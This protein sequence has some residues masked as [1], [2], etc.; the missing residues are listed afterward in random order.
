MLERSYTLLPKEALTK[1]RFELP[2]LES[3]I[4]GTKTL[5][6]N[7]AALVKGINR[8]A[9]HLIKYFTNDLGV[10]ITVNEGKLMISGKFSEQQLNHSFQNYCQEYV[11]CHECKKPDT[12]IIE[13]ANG[14]KVLKCDACGASKPVKRL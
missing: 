14:I 2:K 11:L 10:P 7:F 1:E 12:K 4:Q 8:E 13:Q 6:K 3:H 9:K 5:V